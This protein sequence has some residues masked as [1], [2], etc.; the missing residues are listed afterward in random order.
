MFAQA[1]GNKGPCL[2]IVFDNKYF[3]A[4]DFSLGVRADCASVTM[5]LTRTTCLAGFEKMTK[6]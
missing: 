1:F 5:N 6:S 3:S 2:G 4:H